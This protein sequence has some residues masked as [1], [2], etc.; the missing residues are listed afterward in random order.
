ME[1]GPCSIRFLLI[2][3][4]RHWP[5]S[6]AAVH[7]SGLTFLFQLARGLERIEHHVV[8]LMA[9]VLVDVVAGIELVRHVDRPWLGP[10][11]WIVDCQIVTEFV[12]CGPRETFCQLRRIAE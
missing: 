11:L 3:I 1:H 10:G 7:P 8:A 12:L 2:L 5:T 9:R 6:S 4:P